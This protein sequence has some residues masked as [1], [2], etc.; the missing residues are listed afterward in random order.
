LAFVKRCL[1]PIFN[2]AAPLMEPACRHAYAWHLRRR[3]AS[4]RSPEQVLMQSDYL[5]LHTQSHR[6][7]VLERFEATVDRLIP[8][9]KLR[10]GDDLFRLFPDLPGMR[11]R[12]TAEQVERLHR[13]V[14][15]A[16]ERAGQNIRRQRAAV[17]RIRTSIAPRR[18]G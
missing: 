11:P 16:R 1:E 18:R 17:E 9:A 8:M 13:K 5:K 4:W 7:P 10:H 12:S 15:H 6:Q 3:A 14:G 2:V